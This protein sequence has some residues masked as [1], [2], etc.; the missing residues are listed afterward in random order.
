[1]LLGTLSKLLFLGGAAAGLVVGSA[2]G[3]LY[4]HCHHLSIDKGF[5][6]GGGAVN[7]LGTAPV[8]AFTLGVRAG[9]VVGFGSSSHLKV[10]V[11]PAGADGG[12]TDDAVVAGAEVLLNKLA[13]FEVYSLTFS[14]NGTLLKYSL[15]L[16]PKFLNI[17]GFGALEVLEALALA[18]L[19]LSALYL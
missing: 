14:L 3:A 15:A 8:L 9:L 12:V 2:A 19:R 6:A 13:A 17:E 18:A 11:D 10:K 4:F 5:I 16:S 7:I 1:M